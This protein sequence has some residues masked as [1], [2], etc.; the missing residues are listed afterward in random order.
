MTI[1]ET[2]R[3]IVR[4]L[5]DADFPHIYRMQSDPVTMRYIRAPVTDEQPVRERVAMWES[6]RAQCPGLGVFALENKTDGAFV[7][8][9]TA[10]HVDFDP[11]TGEYEVGY[12][13]AP[14]WW[15]QGLASEIVPPLSRYLFGLSGASHLVAFT[16]P[17]NAASQRVLLKSGFREVGTR[18]VYE[19]VSNEFW[20][21]KKE[22]EE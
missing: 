2:P 7:G 21:E 4:T 10:R 19:G 3:L 16:D 22:Q 1:F 18:Q 13:L 5:L 17:E 11:A 14:E 9:V 15:G 12:A 6:Y 20:L 8:Y